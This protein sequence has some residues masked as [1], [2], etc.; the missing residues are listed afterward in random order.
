[1][2]SHLPPDSLL[3]LQSMRPNR[4]PRDERIIA[5]AT[6]NSPLGTRKDR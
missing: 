2:H 6:V 5:A 4:I 3:G 1:M